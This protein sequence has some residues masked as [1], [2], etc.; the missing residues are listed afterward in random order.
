MPLTPASPNSYWNTYHPK[1]KN[2]KPTRHVTIRNREE[3]SQSFTETDCLVLVLTWRVLTLV[4]MRG[5]P[6]Q[7]QE[8]TTGYIPTNRQTTRRQIDR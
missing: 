5:E 6:P 2:Q 7:G 3:D 1:T 4:L 8:S